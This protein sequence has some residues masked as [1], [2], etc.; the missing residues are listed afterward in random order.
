MKQAFLVFIGGGLGSVLRYLIS[1][2]L[3]PLLHNF[4]LGTFLVNIVGCVIIGLVLGLSVKGQFLSQNSTLFLATGFCGGFT[5]FS[6]F[7]YEKH[8][9]IKNGDLLNFAIYMISSIVV[10]ILAIVLGLWIARY[11]E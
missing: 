6:A 4:F 5:T 9:L 7:A 10:G 3:N 11:L 2:P 1:K 8:Y